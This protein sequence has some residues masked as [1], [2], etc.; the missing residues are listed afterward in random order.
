MFTDGI[1]VDLQVRRHPELCRTMLA[2]LTVANKAIMLPSQEWE[3]AVNTWLLPQVESGQ[4]RAGLERA[5]VEA[6]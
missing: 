6:P 1:E 4:I 2:P 3:M 5:L